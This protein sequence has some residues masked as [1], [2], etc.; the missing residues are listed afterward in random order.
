MKKFLNSFVLFLFLTLLSFSCCAGS[1]RLSGK[2]IRV[3]DG[4]TV[5]V[6]L[7]NGN[8]VKV[9]VWGI[10][11][12]E[13]F[14]S[15]KLT[16][17]ARTCH[18]DPEEIVVLGKKASE[19]ARE[20]LRGKNVVLIGKGRG[21]YGR[22]LGKIMVNGVEDYG[23]MMVREG[24]ACV[25]WKTAPGDYVKAQKETERE[26]RGLWGVNYHLMKCLCY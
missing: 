12:P 19:K 17:Q 8:K 24:Y 3:S 26:R 23:W 21:Y 18:V 7:D 2:V 4:D 13:K 16:R 6:R 5:W 15:K 14:S 22:F 25:Y 1:D 11:T 9:R 10:D 20:V